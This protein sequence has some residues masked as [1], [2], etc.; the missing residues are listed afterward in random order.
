MFAGYLDSSLALRVNDFLEVLDDAFI[1][2]RAD[3]LVVIKSSGELVESG[4]VLE[5]KEDP[6]AV[7]FVLDSDKIKTARL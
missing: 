7:R 6:P 4:A 1:G 5:N 2:Q 3:G